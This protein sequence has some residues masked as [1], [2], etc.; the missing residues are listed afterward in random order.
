MQQEANA[1]LDLSTTLFYDGI[2]APA[3]SLVLLSS[4]LSPPATTATEDTSHRILIQ[5]HLLN[6]A[7]LEAC[8]PRCQ[9]EEQAS[10]TMWPVLPFRL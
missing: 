5:Q 1:V 6:S 8:H 10:L 4:P 9:E 7:Y 2:E 3:T